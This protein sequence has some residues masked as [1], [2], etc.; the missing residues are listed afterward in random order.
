MLKVALQYQKAFY[1][2]YAR[3]K[4]FHEEM[5]KTNGGVKKEDWEYVASVLPLHEIQVD[6]PPNEDDN[7]NIFWNYSQET[8]HKSDPKTEIESYL[9]ETWVPCVKTI[10]FDILGWWKVNL[11]RYP[12]LESIAREVLSIP[13]STI[14]SE[15]AFSNGGRV[16]SDYRTCLTPK[17]VEALVF[18]QDWLKGESISLFSEENLDEIHQLEQ[19]ITSQ[20]S[21]DNL[22]DDEVFAS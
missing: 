4:T 12:I 19:E 8:R 22:D 9:Q 14:A 2:I 7:D 6:T 13:A 3:D 10:E 11:T 1:L 18:M 16:I 5:D 20:T 21:V 15:S 17:M